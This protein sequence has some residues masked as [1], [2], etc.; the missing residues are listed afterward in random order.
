MQFL[1]FVARGG[2]WK[3][4][5]KRIL[6]ELLT[7]Q[8]V[9]MG[10]GDMG[11]PTSANAFMMVGWLIDLIYT[12][13]H[14][15]GLWASILIKRT[16][17]RELLPRPSP[18]H[19]LPEVWFFHKILSTFKSFCCWCGCRIHDARW[20]DTCSSVNVC[21]SNRGFCRTNSS[22]V[23]IPIRAFDATVSAIIRAGSNSATM[24]TCEAIW[25]QVSNVLYGQ[26][27]ALRASR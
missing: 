24:A 15:Q 26:G 12:P 23:P 3:G 21:N 19:F 16:G 11:M 22:S 2:M 20:P 13:L 1:N 17:K 7:L 18:H 27:L 8:A 14:P 9:R 5:W 10:K 4:L 6:I 25:S